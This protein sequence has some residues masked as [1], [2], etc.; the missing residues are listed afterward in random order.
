M[1]QKSEINIIEYKRILLT[2]HQI[3]HIF[4]DLNQ[5]SLVGSQNTNSFVKRQ[6]STHH[7]QHQIIFLNTVGKNQEKNMHS[8]Y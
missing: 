7:R 1:C 6:K 4:L 5:K 2:K 8:Y 3:I